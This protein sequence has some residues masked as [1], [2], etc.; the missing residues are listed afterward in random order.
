MS[1]HIYQ[2]CWKWK[3]VVITKGVFLSI[4][5]YIMWNNIIEKEVETTY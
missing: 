1:C 3:W 5:Y 2:I 4:K